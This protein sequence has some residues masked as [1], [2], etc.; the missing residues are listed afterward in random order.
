MNDRANVVDGTRALVAPDGTRWE[1]YE[2]PAVSYD[3]R[4]SLIFDSERLVRRVRQ[5]PESWRTVT[6]DELYR[7]SW[8]K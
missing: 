7:L 4:P 6:A 2:R 5:Y 1:V 3:P 8:G